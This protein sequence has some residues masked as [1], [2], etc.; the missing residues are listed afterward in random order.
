M[1]AIAKHNKVP[2]SAKKARL[3]V[4]LV[5]GM[6]VR[7]ALG[8]LNNLPQKAAPLVHKLLLSA[9]NNWSQNTENNKEAVN[10]LYVASI[11]VNQ[12]A[13]LKRIRPASKGRAHRIKKHSCHISVCL[14]ALPAR[15][16]EQK[17]ITNKESKVLDKREKNTKE[18][19]K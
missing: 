8:I 13:A 19:N 1:E 10:N 3:V 7:S 18:K 6:P 15:S 16:Q 4:D 9:K 2:M 11:W 5:R 14:R 12:G 17:K